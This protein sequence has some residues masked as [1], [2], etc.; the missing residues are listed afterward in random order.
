MWGGMTGVL[1]TTAAAA[2]TAAVAAVDGSALDD[3]RRALPPVVGQNLLGLALGALVLLVGLFGIGLRDLRR[4]RPGR[5][6]AIAG[7]AFKESVRRRVLWVTPLAM[8]GVVA[9]GRFVQG[10]DAAD[11]LRQLT[12][13][14]FLAAGFVAVLVCVVLACTNLQRDLES[15]VIF[16]IVTKPATRLEIVLGKVIGFAG[17]G[18]AV[19]GV[20]A[21]FTVVYLGL[22]AASAQR[23]IA[24]ELGGSPDPARR[25]ALAHYRDVG[26]LA[27]RTLAGPR[28][29]QVFAAEPDPAERLRTISG[30]AGQDAVV[31]YTLAPADVPAGAG[32][33]VRLDLDGAAGAARVDFLDADGFALVNTPAIQNGGLAELGEAP[34]F[35][36]V[37]PRGARELAEAG[38]FLV[39]VRPAGREDL[40]LDVRTE[41]TDRLPPVTLVV[42]G[43][44]GLGR[45]IRP[46]GEPIFRGRG[47]QFGQQL[48]GP[49]TAAGQ[50][51]VYEFRG[52][53]AAAVGGRVPV[54]MR[55]GVERDGDSG[56]SAE[57]T[58]LSVTAV[59][60]ATGARFGP[61]LVRPETLRPAFAAVP[62]EAAAGGDFDLIVEN[63][64]AGRYVGVEPGTAAVVTGRQPFVYNLLKSFAGLWLLCVLVVSVGV[65]CSTFLSWPIA[66]A[67]CV[68]LLSVRWAVDQVGDVLRPGF[69]R[70][71][72][73]DLFRDSAAGTEATAATVEAVTDALQLVASLLP[74]LTPYGTG[75]Y[76]SAGVSV[77]YPELGYALLITLGFGLP[78][79]VLG[80]V[81]LRF[82]EVAA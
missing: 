16:T 36:R 7:V 39:R 66:L 27:T 58:T 37:E 34:T 24:A 67:L 4:L 21:L 31:P 81:F 54:E 12:G 48:A 18:A 71:V 32:M 45:P 5:A 20:M 26:L 43:G 75:R 74:D 79:A 50:V 33:F 47:G 46:A 17:V 61:A 9:L 25:A 19:L 77:P 56:D 51:A 29:V 57:L 28:D 60:R 64:T 42:P 38:R 30:A 49:D 78:L 22:V 76:L 41:G 23:D 8:L 62:A 2:T 13:Y 65:F 69:G 73:S 40:A 14:C 59:N 15:K 55:F 52:V 3:L 70:Q 10:E 1:A 68:F 72:G 82:K 35:V 6:L 63:L 53:E 80:Y 11:T 44:E